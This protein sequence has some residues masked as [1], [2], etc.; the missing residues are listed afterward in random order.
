MR[1]FIS[2]RKNE[3]VENIDVENN[4]NLSDNAV[5]AT[6]NALIGFSEQAFS[7]SVIDGV[8]MTIQF[9]IDGKSYFLVGTR[10]GELITANGG[11]IDN[12]NKTLFEQ[13][14]QEIKEETFG[15]FEL[16]KEND[17]YL[18][19]C[20]YTNTTH[21]IILDK[22]HITNDYNWGKFVYV[23]F[24]VNVQGFTKDML[25]EI[26]NHMNPTANF[27]HNFYEK[28]N[29]LAPP[30][31][32]PDYAE[33]WQNTT[34]SR[35][36]IV[37][38]LTLYC[39]NQNNLLVEP[40]SVFGGETNEVAIKN[41]FSS[42]ET[43]NNFFDTRNNKLGNYSERPKYFVVSKNAMIKAANDKTPIRD[44]KGVNITQDFFDALHVQAT[45]I[46]PANKASDPQHI[47]SRSIL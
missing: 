25:S 12:K 47:L 20:N 2:T 14:Q 21:P 40:K 37:S 26:A 34:N 35:E 9:E 4:I 36:D 15:V 6:D 18:L 32:C 3:M 43:L 28:F 27:W 10:L 44:I 16:I 33:H 24:T 39:N 23:T 42:I 1:L 41:C 29:K 5:Q 19:K 45:I 22:A 7:K 13:L 38:A 30:R 31:N 17:Q 8:G 46:A 11:A